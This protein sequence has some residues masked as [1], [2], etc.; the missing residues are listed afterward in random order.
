MAPD[1]SA[2][3]PAVRRVLSRAMPCLPEGIRVLRMRSASDYD[4]GPT[5]PIEPGLQMAVPSTAG[6]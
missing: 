4:V 2:D 3:R 5:E 1:C 6:R